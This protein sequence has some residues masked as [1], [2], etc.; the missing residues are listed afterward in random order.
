MNNIEYRAPK[1]TIKTSRNGWE[2]VSSIEDV[3]RIYDSI[4]EYLDK[5]SNLSGEEISSLFNT[6][7]TSNI[8]D[9]R[10]EDTLDNYKAD[11]SFDFASKKR[12]VVKKD[13]SRKGRKQKEVISDIFAPLEDTLEILNQSFN[14]F[15]KNGKFTEEDKETNK[16]NTEDVLAEIETL[17]KN[18]KDRFSKVFDK[19][20]LISKLRTEDEKSWQKWRKEQEY[21]RQVE[22]GILSWYRAMKKGEEEEKPSWW[23]YS[24]KKNPDYY[25]MIIDESTGEG[26]IYKLKDESDVDN[27]GRGYKKFYAVCSDEIEKE[28][29]KIPNADRKKAEEF[30][31]GLNKKYD[32][33]RKTEPG[34]RIETGFEDSGD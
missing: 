19:D 12:G 18:L 31:R 13:F 15:V 3:D 2:F 25:K 14:F 8:R 26:T 29:G 11:A 34:W 5:M 28:I 32:T 1:G 9:I 30:I 7:V 4:A 24:R 10:D 21:K 27:N 20:T 22:N 16:K 33:I 17:R 6:T 23:P